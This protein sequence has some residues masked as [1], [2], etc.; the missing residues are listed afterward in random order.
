[1][2]TKFGKLY[3]SVLCM[4]KKATGQKTTTKLVRHNLI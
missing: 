1:M 4:V 3:K 2:G